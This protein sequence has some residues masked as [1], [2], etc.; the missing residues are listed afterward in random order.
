MLGFWVYGDFVP[1]FSSQPFTPYMSD[2]KINRGTIIFVQSLTTY[3]TSRDRPDSET[4]RNR[5]STPP[6]ETKWYYNIF[7]VFP[8]LVHRLTWVISTNYWVI[9][10]P[11]IIFFYTRTGVVNPK[12]PDVGVPGRVYRTGALHSP[13]RPPTWTSTKITMGGCWRRKRLCRQS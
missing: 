8:P 6:V 3:K 2:T 13:T 1:L 12:F 10:F 11:I 7:K 5:S 9:Y 4:L